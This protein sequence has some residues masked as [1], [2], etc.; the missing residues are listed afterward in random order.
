MEMA[1]K[2]VR[3]EAEYRAFPLALLRVDEVVNFEI[4]LWHESR[5]EHVLF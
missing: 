5:G 2:P 4:C 1:N 3:S